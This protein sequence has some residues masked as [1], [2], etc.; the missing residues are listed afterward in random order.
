MAT[1]ARIHRSS[2]EHRK[3]TAHDHNPKHRSSTRETATAQ[4][5]NGTVE[6][7]FELIPKHSTVEPFQSHEIG[8]SRTRTTDPT[9]AE[10]AKTTKNGRKKQPPPKVF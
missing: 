5:Q 3:N 7:F 6:P 2:R 8:R 4:P 9:P 10:Q 1:T